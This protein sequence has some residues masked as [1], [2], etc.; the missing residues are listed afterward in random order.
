MVDTVRIYD[1]ARAGIG[2]VAHS[3]VLR[4]ELDA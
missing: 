3:F 4:D 2:E 1:A